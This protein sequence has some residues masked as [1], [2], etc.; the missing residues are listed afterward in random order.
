MPKHW[1]LVKAAGKL[2]EAAG[3]DFIATMKYAIGLTK[4]QWDWLSVQFS[5]S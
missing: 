2:K 4:Q 5:A 3:I 1:R